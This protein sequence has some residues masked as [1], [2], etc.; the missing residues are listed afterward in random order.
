MVCFKKPSSVDFVRL[1]FGGSCTCS[2]NSRVW[3]Q[4]SW[5]STTVRSTSTLSLGVAYSPKPEMFQLGLSL[6]CKRNCTKLRLKW[7]ESVRIVISMSAQ[8]MVW[9]CRNWGHNPLSSTWCDFQS[10]K[11]SQACEI[12]SEESSYQECLRM[13]GIRMGCLGLPL[14]FGDSARWSPQSCVYIF[15]A[16]DCHRCSLH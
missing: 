8:P 11:K 13:Q 3:P 2:Y 12:S 14:L 15:W 10:P 16:G 7:Q 6:N 1:Q 9:A 5:A 4:I